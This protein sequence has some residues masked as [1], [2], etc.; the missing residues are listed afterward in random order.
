M[1]STRQEPLSRSDFLR[2][3]T[4]GATGLGLATAAV[5][6]R[7]AGPN[8]S[9]KGYVVAITHGPADATRVML[10]LFT[11]TRLPA[12]DNHVWFAIDGG[13]VCLKAQADKLSSPLFTKQGTASELLKQIRGQGIAVHI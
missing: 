12:G 6:A 4:L 7:A 8:D 1:D 9:R 10:A 13:Q 5:T 3:S 2:V 11:A